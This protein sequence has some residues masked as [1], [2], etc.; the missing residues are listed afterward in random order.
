[1]PCVNSIKERQTNQQANPNPQPGVAHIFSQ[2][3]E[4]EGGGF[5]ESLRPA[6]PSKLQEIQSPHLNETKPQKGIH[7]ISI[8]FLFVSAIC[9]SAHLKAISSATFSGESSS[10][11]S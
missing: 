2:L 10:V 6:L 3:W 11:I 4:A 9:S 5:L 1:M 8:L 7:S